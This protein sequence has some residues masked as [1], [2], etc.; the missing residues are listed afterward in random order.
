M[1]LIINKEYVFEEDRPF[2]S[3][4][5]STVLKTNDGNVL[6][7]WFGG[8]KEGADDVAV[9]LSRRTADGWG[10]PLKVADE[11]G[12]PHWNPVLFMG[13]NDEVI[14]Y[15]KVGHKISKWHTR[16]ITSNDGGLTWSAPNSLVEG[17]IGGRGP[18]KNKPIR[19]HDGTI[20]APASIEEH[21]WDAFV[22]ISYDQGQTWRQSELVPVPRNSFTG[23]GVIQPT[24]WE[25][26][27]GKVHMLLRSSEGY[28]FRSD[29]EDGGKTWSL[30]YPT[31]LPNN[32]S[33][34]DLAKLPDGRIVLAY[35]PVG[36][37]WG[38][39]TPLILSISE[40]NGLTWQNICVLENEEEEYSYP[41]IIADGKE[42]LLVYTWRRE[43]I[44]FWRA[45]FNDSTN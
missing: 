23:K 41:S 29:S 7:A 28:I 45:A 31:K 24:L 34:I 22:D 12:V 2:I 26:D 19:L 44:A 25:S 1:K 39:R 3:C 36:Q 8:T 38:P 33:G 16:F 18:V 21:S 15:Y 30:A 40:D 42:I 32:N 17:D 14:L 27:Y 20:L 37:N 4:H 43:R 9:W 35:N 10:Y 11:E 13:L 6:A 5:A